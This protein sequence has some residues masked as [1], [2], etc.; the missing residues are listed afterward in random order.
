MSALVFVTWGLGAAA[1][2]APPPQCAPPQCED[3]EI[4]V[5]GER[6]ER[7]LAEA[8]SSVSVFTAEAIEAL[9]GADRLD[10]LLTQIPNI[11]LG[12][13]GEGPTIRGQDTTGVLRDLPA[14]LGGTRPRATLQVDGRAV[15]FNEFVFG[16]APL[17]DVQRVEVFRSPQT[18]TQGRN[19]IAG[20]I[21][22]E[23]NDPTFEWEAAGRL[24]AGNEDLLQGSAL[25]SGPVLADQLAFR[26]AA[27][28]R[29]ARA[30]SRIADFVPDA[31]PNEEGHAL[32]R[33]KLLAEPSML[34]GTALELTYTHAET[35]AP[36]IEGV[37]PPFEQRRDPAPIYGSFVTNVD[38][39]SAVFRTS[40]ADDLRST[41]T[42]SFGNSLIRRLVRPG[43]G[44]T[45]ADVD[46]LSG[47][48]LIRWNPSPAVS[49]AGGVHLL[50]Q[51]LRQ[52]IDLSASIGTGAFRDDQFSLGVFGDLAMPL[53]PR[54]EA[55][56][57]LRYQ[58]DR[59][60]RV[61]A[62]ANQNARFGI[63][64]AGSFDAWLPKLTLTYA[65][66]AD[67][68]VGALLQRA[69]NAGG[70][71]IRL[72]NGATDTFEAETLWAY[73]VFGRAS[74]WDGR[75]TARLNLFYNDISDAQRPQV[76]T[77]FLPGGP[78]V[79]TT[80][81]VNAPAAETYGM[82]LDL[83]WR[84]S[85]QLAVSLALGLLGTK[86]LESVRP[87]D[88]ILG[89]AFQ[90]SPGTSASVSVDWRPAEAWRLSLQARHNSSYFSD[91]VNTPQR[92]I[93][94]ATVIDARAA[95]TLGSATL[96]AY[97]R[98]VA[99]DF[100]LTYLFSAVSGTAGDPR[101]VGIGIE[102]RF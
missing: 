43:V 37:R 17:W 40:L 73:E 58:R 76:R 57:G 27:D 60:E 24:I 28:V 22:I 68:R 93:S 3:A 8:P 72:D 15:G 11:Q 14:F 92:A 88:P 53:A 38:S 55:S 33:L 84:P 1:P 96:F 79:L 89:K 67:L 82:E 34:P 77:I 23:T 95:W 16:V 101:Q 36:Q 69:Y 63:D 59:Q 81:I 2:V 49:I 97:V 39:G 41:T 18:T 94:A 46:D 13:G 50:R 48:T 7:R 56:L 44:R 75:L 29:G 51:R 31:D 19:A 20:A 80:D 74:L 9:S 32:V 25:V 30:S 71:T 64:F 26:V 62:I 85:R 65:P 98:N 102:A 47:E 4:V 5:T 83:A 86:T 66:T 87:D 12:S 91:D 99:D 100:Y 61:G 78:G 35:T 6:V 21:F 10:E 45:R 52:E 90:R 54:L 70:A 42:F